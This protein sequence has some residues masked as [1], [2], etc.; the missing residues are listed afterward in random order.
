MTYAIQG[1]LQKAV[2]LSK[3]NELQNIEIEAILK[4]TLEET[5]SLF[6]SILERANIDTDELNQAYTNKLKNYPSV[7]GDN[8]QYGQYIGAK[9]NELLNKAESYMKEYEDEYIS[10]EHVLRAA[11]DIDDTTKQF[12]GNKEEVVKEI[13]T[14]VRGNHVTSQNPE[15]NYEAL[16][17][18]GRDLVEEVRQGKMDP[19]IGRDE[20]IR[21]TIRILSRKTKQS[22]INRGTWCR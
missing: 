19:V 3:E 13:I 11:M 7:Q 22:S 14:K 8:I 10:M 17:K 9:A 5:D 18:Y 2:E 15:V 16:E 6:K 4:G 12:V 21:N 1:A 20:E